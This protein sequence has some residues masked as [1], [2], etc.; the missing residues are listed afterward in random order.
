MFIIFIAIAV[1]AIG[2]GGFFALT[3][4][5]IN[6]IQKMTFEDMLLYT[7]K[8]K[9]KAIV[10][11]GVIKNREAS[12]TVYGKNG[13]I[14]PQDKHIYE[15][16]SITKTFT[17]SLLF[18]AVG[19]G[20]INLDDK[21]SKY[22]NLP[23]KEYYPTIKSLITHTSGYK[24]YY[25]DTQMISNF[26]HGRNS[27]YGISKKQLIER[28][29]KINLKDRNYDF[30]YSNFGMTV[31]GTILTEVYREDYTTIINDYIVKE[32]N[33]NN[34][35]ISDGSGDLENYWNW[36]E[37]DAYIPAGALT[38]NIEDMLKYAQLQ[39]NET[40][41]YLSGT[42]KV[43]ANINATSGSNAKM[44][45]RLDSVG[46]AWIIDTIN[47]IIWHNGGTSN[48]NCYLGFD[49]NK[50]IAVVILSNLSPNYR[51]PATVMGIKLLTD[52]QK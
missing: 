6:Q 22:I 32:F 12:Y 50:Q 10:T 15:I 47:N 2:I 52:L 23:E 33:L 18:K 13:T 51:I 46:A 1:I 17:A 26:F 21:I 20:K 9:E 45:I 3:I 37:N 14:L 38:S 39:I 7:T 8:N 11:V 43:L 40:P 42:H 44:N 4:Y 25:F 49:L 35:K 41:E 28:I 30:S 16:G 31:I 24:S 5:R 48:H 19:E 36:L 27:F 34:T 29:G